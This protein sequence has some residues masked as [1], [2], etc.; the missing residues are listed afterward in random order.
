MIKTDNPFTRLQ[1]SR[2]LPSLPQVLLQIIAFKDDSEI[3]I[4][5]LVKIIAKDPA[6]TAKTLR[7]VNSAYFNLRSNITSLERAVLYLGAEN[8]KNI[9]I[10][11]S[12][13]HVFNGIKNRGSFP[14][15]R[16]WWNSFSCAIFSRKLA[17][18]TQYVNTDEA[19]V[20]GLLHN[21]GKLLLWLNF[22]KEYKAI[23]PLIG[24]QSD[25]CDIEKQQ[26]GITHSEAGDWLIRHWE[27]SSLM[28]DA[29]LYHHEPLD[30]IKSGFPLVKITYLAHK[31]TKIQ[32]EEDAISAFN[33]GNALL[34]I[35]S[36]RMQAIL[37]ETQDEIK[38]IANSLDL[39]VQSPA[40]E[41]EV[42]PDQL[43]KHTLQLV[44]TVQDNSLL[45]CFL[46]DLLCTNDRD[47]VLQATERGMNLLMEIDAILF[48]LLDAENDTLAG[49]TSPLNH[50]HELALDL[51][52][53]GKAGSSL[54]ARS[55][56]EQR[57]INAHELTPSDTLSLADSQLLDLVGKNGM[58]YVPMIA[59]NTP[60]GVIILGLKDSKLNGDGRILR[61]MANQAALSLHLHNIREEQAKKIQ[62]ERLAATAMA[63]AKIAHE[64]N[65]PLA[66][67]KNYC[68]IFELKFSPSATLKE[69]LKFLNDEID[70][71]SNLIQQLNHFAPPAPQKLEKIDLN[72]L[73]TDLT[74]ILSKSILFTSQ[75]K[76]HF[77]PAPDL[78]PIQASTDEIKQVII[79]LVKNSAEAIQNGGN[80]YLETSR[81]G[82]T[83]DNIPSGKSAPLQDRV[84]L[85]IRDDGPGISDKIA[86]N[87]FDPFT[88]TK[89][90]GNSGLGLSIVKNII[91]RLHGT[92]TCN[93]SKEEGTTFTIMLP[94]A[95]I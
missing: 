56:H 14:L 2:S 47:T 94:I 63:A 6:I 22:P 19:Y 45:T 43:D 69:D 89:G 79:N 77:S 48:F 76:I 75:I 80:I 85:T 49:C 34:G 90:Q 15:D 38:I 35:D 55:I 9:A 60:L 27:L 21:L 24:S 26:I 29:V 20:A 42:K 64:V 1:D 13:H 59:Q 46:E 84:I 18:Q 83:A 67:I 62:E 53:S 39:A 93:S 95:G 3:D 54:L 36:Q 40:E 51:T 5:E 7:L 82:I 23:L 25:E 66:I 74:K 28:A 10:T 52:L 37:S 31:L 72:L 11:A 81:S 78:P 73:L 12:I 16:F 41:R 70:R 17:Q 61:L 65:N 86:A 50:F 57:I 4:K 87:L 71:I 8:I 58:V 68:K 30:R 91:S 44:T 32:N 88:S 92:I 33:V